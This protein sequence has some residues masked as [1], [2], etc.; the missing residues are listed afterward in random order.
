MK[1]IILLLCFTI[2]IATYA[3]ITQ[4]F[5]FS[6]LNG[7]FQPLTAATQVN[8]A[9]FA[10]DDEYYHMPIGFTFNYR[11]TNYD[12]L[13]FDTYS[14]LFF[15]GHPDSA[16]EDQHLFAANYNDYTDRSFRT[17]SANSLSPILYKTEG[18]T[19]SKIMK[20]EMRNVG[21]YVDSI[22]AMPNICNFQIWL[23]EIDNAIEVR[24]G[25]NQVLSYVTGFPDQG[26]HTGAFT[27][28]SNGN[29]TFSYNISGNPANPTVNVINTAPDA[30]LDSLPAEG[31]IYRFGPSI[32]G[33]IQ[34]SVFANLS[35]Y[36]NPAKEML[37]LSLALT[38]RNSADIVITDITGKVLF[39]NPYAFSQGVQQIQ[40]PVGQLTSGFYFVGVKNGDQ[41]TFKKFLKE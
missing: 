21:F 28:D 36:P 40:I 11:G 4:S 12:S 26:P 32:V 23:Y 5:Q 27:L 6:L 38:E 2:S 25:P 33:A 20:I 41:T 37:T 39:E 24:M 18:V 30:Y 7:A 34:P 9:N 8:P 13:W 22:S 1:K 19:G 10:W 35:V 3:Q 15:G 17:D 29:S 14:G 16:A 31:V